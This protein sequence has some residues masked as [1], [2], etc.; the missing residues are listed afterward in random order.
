[1]SRFAFL[2]PG[3]GSQHPGMGAEL[4]AAFPEARAVFDEADRALET[5][6][7]RVCFEGTDAE[8]AMT[9]TTQ[10]AILTASVAA[11]RV[12]EARG[13]R[14]DAAAGHS[15]GEYSAHVAA[16]TL[17]FADAVR[18]VRS[19][20]RFMQEAVPVGEGAMAAVLG[21]DADV[22][23]AICA[24]ASAGTVVR[25]A[26]VNAPGQ[27]VVAGHADAV[28]RAAE[29][30]R[31]RGASRV[32]PLN[33][34]APFHS[35][36][37]RPAAERLA[38]VLEAVEFADPAFPVRAN[39]DGEPVT[40]A[41]AAREALVRQVDAPVQW[42]RTIEAFVAEGIDTFVEVG[43]GRVLAGLNRRIARG[44]RTLGVADPDGL[45]RAVAELAGGR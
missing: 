3:Q 19:R 42:Q 29:L 45:E 44:S 38:P 7:S 2:F 18:V 25:A 24:E 22:V 13:L 1:M 14:P 31:E 23:D 36:L 40:A 28:E 27:I 10:P 39:V 11:L 35:P 43:P 9:E 4:A 33:V 30:A 34:S 32:V 8:L 16:G 20:G 5:G 26:N 41:G 21:L 6:L 12:L 37:M 15:L 17:R